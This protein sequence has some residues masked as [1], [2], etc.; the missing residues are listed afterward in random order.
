MNRNLV[1]GTHYFNKVDSNDLF[2][3][4]Y[5]LDAIIGDKITPDNLRSNAVVL[6]DYIQALLLHRK[7][8][9]DTN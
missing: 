7:E 9:G 6:K 8:S 5:A 1:L 2:V 3:I 4:V